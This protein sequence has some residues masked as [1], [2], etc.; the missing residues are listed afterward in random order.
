MIVRLDRRERLAFLPLDDPDAEPL[1]GDM[2]DELRAGSIH[3]VEPGGLRFS[4][5]A[6][7]TRLIRALGAPVPAGALGRLYE[8]V[9]RN[10]SRLG[11]HVPDGEAPRRYP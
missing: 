3:L 5:G 10:R 11:P 4:R 9:A 2:A 8:P 1:L 7:L 6:A